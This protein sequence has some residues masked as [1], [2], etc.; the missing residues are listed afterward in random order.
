MKQQVISSSWLIAFYAAMLVLSWAGSFGG[1]GYISHPLDT[2]V[3]AVVA[4]VIYYWG[5]AV[6][7]PAALVD[8][9]DE[10]TA[11][12]SPAAVR[13]PSRAVQPAYRQTH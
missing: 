6:A 7:L 8:F 13:R 11:V 4:L 3:V 10:D 1:H 12:Q 2:L 5:S 9:N